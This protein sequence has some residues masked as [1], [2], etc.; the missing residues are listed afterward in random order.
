[1]EAVFFHRPSITREEGEGQGKS[2]QGRGMEFTEDGR[3]SVRQSAGSGDPRRAL[4][5]T[6]VTALRE[7]P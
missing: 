1:M 4:F 2:F 7:M 3:P 6:A 5:T